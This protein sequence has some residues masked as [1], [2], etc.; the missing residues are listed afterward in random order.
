MSEFTWWQNTLGEILL[1]SIIAGVV[2]I[3]GWA[4]EQQVPVWGYLLC[5]LIATIQWRM[6][7]R[8]TKG[9]VGTDSR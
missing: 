3:T 4:F 7:L 2:A 1:F 9:A 5:G 8:A 6:P